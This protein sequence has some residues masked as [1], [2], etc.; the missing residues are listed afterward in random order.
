MNNNKS[1]I[2]NCRE[3]LATDP[4]QLKLKARIAT[5]CLLTYAEKNL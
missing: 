4:F 5:M 2:M 1:S 3:T